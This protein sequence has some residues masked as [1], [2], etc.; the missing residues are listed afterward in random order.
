MDS[1]TYDCRNKI[2]NKT[3]RVFLI[4]DSLAYK[5]P[6]TLSLTRSDLLGACFM[7]VSCLLL[8]TEDR[9]DM[10]LFNTVDFHWPMAVYHRR[11]NSS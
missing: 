6:P 3:E 4:L 2:Y 5:F 1:C 11:Q 9:G 10:F 8:D 7:L